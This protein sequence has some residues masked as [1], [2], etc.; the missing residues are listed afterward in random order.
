MWVT[1]AYASQ[2]RESVLEEESTDLKGLHGAALLFRA[3]A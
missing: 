2:A 1:P 3:A